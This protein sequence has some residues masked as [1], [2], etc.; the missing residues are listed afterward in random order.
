M[1]SFEQGEATCDG[2]LKDAE[3]HRRMHA[4]ADQLG[5]YRRCRFSN[6]ET[7]EVRYETIRDCVADFVQMFDP[8]SP[9]GLLLCGPTGAGKDHLLAAALLRATALYGASELSPCFVSG[10]EL[11]ASLKSAIG[12]RRSEDDVLG[13]LMRSQLLAISD[14]LTPGGLSDYEVRCL[15]RLMDARSRDGLPTWATINVQ[16]GDEAVKA[17]GGPLWGRMSD[18][19]TVVFCDLPSWRKVKVLI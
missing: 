3:W 15:F 18:G 4:I 1:A 17:F 19:A 9:T 6:F 2:K 16:S 13:P 12:A 11:F 14:P 7:P 10:V 8:W 5:G